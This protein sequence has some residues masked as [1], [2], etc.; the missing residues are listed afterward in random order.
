[1]VEKR[2][3]SSRQ[4]RRTKRPANTDPII[5]ANDKVKSLY[6]LTETFQTEDAL[7]PVTG[8]EIE[9]LHAEIIQEQGVLFKAQEKRQIETFR[10]EEKDV[11]GHGDVEAFKS[12]RSM[13]DTGKPTSLIKI[14]SES[15]WGAWVA[16]IMRA[17]GILSE[18]I[19]PEGE[20]LL[21]PTKKDSGTHGD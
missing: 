21:Y 4:K 3:R 20:I 13:F 2:S 11:V 17:S 19:S 6:L 5:T 12:F 15:P 8:R 9:A 1:M 16:K 14:E 18:T 10:E 7:D